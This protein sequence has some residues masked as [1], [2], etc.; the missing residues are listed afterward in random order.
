MSKFKVFGGVGHGGKDP[1][2]V[3]NGLK[4]ADI[5]LQC[6]LAWRTEMERHNVEILLSRYKDEN[7]DLSEEIRECNAFNPDLAVDFHTNAGGG[8]GFEVFH[9]INGG[10]GKTFAQNCEKHV[11]ALGQNSRGVK[12]KK[13]SSGKDYFGF[14]RQTKCPAIITECGFIDN[15]ADI[16]FIDTLTEQKAYGVAIAKATLETLGIPYKPLESNNSNNTSSPDYIVATGAFSQVENARAEVQRL[17]DKG[18]SSAYIHTC[19]K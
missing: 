6:A 13:N 12:T 5:N 8:D 16:S 7:D 4:E 17:K 2:A 15:K 10:K 11:L 1:G 18:I 9:S 19:K 14:I 3:G